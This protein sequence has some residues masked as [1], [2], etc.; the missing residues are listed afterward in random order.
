[1][2][3]RWEQAFRANYEAD[4]GAQLQTLIARFELPISSKEM[5]EGTIDVVSSSCAF[6]IL[7]GRDIEAFLADQCYD[8]RPPVATYCL[9]FDLFGRGA[10]RLILRP[11]LEFLDLADLYEC[12][13]E[14]P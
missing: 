4:K 7:D 14:S 12:P 5:L 2:P 9:T 11:D 8:A 1:M 6:L 13:L 10:A 3:K